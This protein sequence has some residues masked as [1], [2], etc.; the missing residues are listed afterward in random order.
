MEMRFVYSLSNDNCVF[1]IG[2]TRDISKRYKEHC[3]S[4]N[5]VGNYIQY[6]FI[7]NKWPAITIIDY[8]PD[9]KAYFKEAE[10]IN[11]FISCGHYLCNGTHNTYN[12]SIKPEKP[13]F[14]LKKKIK[15]EVIASL[16]E[17]QTRYITWH[18]QQ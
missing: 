2:C 6:M 9:D 13:A 17:L 3:Q 14:R 1:Y 18:K 8:L 11:L 7:C 5:D 10:L 12:T 15:K 16:K 4:H